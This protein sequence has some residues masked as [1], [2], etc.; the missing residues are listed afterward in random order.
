MLVNLEREI[1]LHDRP[2]LVSD[3]DRHLVARSAGAA[4]SDRIPCHVGK[5]AGR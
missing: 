2:G 4:I 1:Y 5:R 3:L